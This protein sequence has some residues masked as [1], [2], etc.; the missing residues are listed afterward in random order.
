M[1]AG[2]A[3]LLH[4]RANRQ[5]ILMDDDRYGIINAKNRDE[6]SRPFERCFHAALLI[7][8]TSGLKTR[9][10][11]GSN[12]LPLDFG[13]LHSDRIENPNPSTHSVILVVVLVVL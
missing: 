10:L 12:P 7:N 4:A 2:Q 1:A 8:P 9:H 13:C 11:D 3:I 5:L 6:A